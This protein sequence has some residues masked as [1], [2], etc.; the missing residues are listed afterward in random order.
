[1]GASFSSSTSMAMTWLAPKARAIW[2]MLVPTP[3]VATT[4]TVSP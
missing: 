4:A 2:T 3:P 1:M